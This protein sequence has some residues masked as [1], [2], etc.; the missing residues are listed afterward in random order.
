MPDKIF[1][2]SRTDHLGDAIQ[3]GVLFR[4]CPAVR[5]IRAVWSNCSFKFL[6]VSLFAPF[7]T[8]TY[9]EFFDHFGILKSIFFPAQ[10]NWLRQVMIDFES[11]EVTTKAFCFSSRWCR[12]HDISVFIA[13]RLLWFIH[14][15][16]T[17]IQ[18]HAFDNLKT[19]FFSIFAGSSITFF[20]LCKIEGN[21]F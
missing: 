10:F 1:S 8:P 4:G 9:F 13:N 5:E 21:H 18:H 16:A 11:V 3:R 7:Y 12:F 19:L 17:S 14:L 2:F 15:V 20:F 6:T